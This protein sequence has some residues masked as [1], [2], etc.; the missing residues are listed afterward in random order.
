MYKS[1]LSLSRVCFSA[2]TV[3]QWKQT[4]DQVCEMRQSLVERLGGCAPSLGVNES[5]SVVNAVESGV[6]GAFPLSSVRVP[7]K[8]FSPRVV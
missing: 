4:S 1:S 3:F 2:R 6:R 7:V 8:S 5:F